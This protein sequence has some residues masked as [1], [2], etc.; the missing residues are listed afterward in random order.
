M[1]DLQPD[2]HNS[3]DTPQPDVLCEQLLNVLYDGLLKYFLA[4]GHIPVERGDSMQTLDGRC[5]LEVIFHL[6]TDLKYE[7]RVSIESGRAILQVQS[8]TIQE[9]TAELQGVESTTTNHFE[10]QA[11]PLYE[12]IEMDIQRIIYT[13]S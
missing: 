12:A 8:D 3:Y 11:R 10:E 9:K 5:G 13:N 2:E 4:H 1:T 6:K 7:L